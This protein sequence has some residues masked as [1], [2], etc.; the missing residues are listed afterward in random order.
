M[1]KQLLFN[2]EARRAILRGVKRES[3][4]ITL[5]LRGQRDPGQ[6]VR[7][8]TITRTVYGGQ[9]DRAG[10]SYENMGAEMVKEVASKTSDTAGDGTTT[11]TVLAEAIF[12]EGLKNVTAG[13]NLGLKRGSPGGR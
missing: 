7:L 13:T 12:R 2:D 1:A 4:Q 6:E 3:G 5:N 9:G 10:R 11:A 8:P